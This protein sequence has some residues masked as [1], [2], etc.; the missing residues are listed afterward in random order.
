MRCP[1]AINSD[2][3]GDD[4][5]VNNEVGCSGSRVLFPIVVNPSKYPPPT[6]VKLRR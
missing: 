1:Q 3:K 4:D 6:V 2:D 5:D